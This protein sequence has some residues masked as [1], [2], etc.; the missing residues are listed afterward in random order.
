MRSTALVTILSW[1][2]LVISWEI[3]AGVPRSL[4]EFRAK[5]PYV[6]TRAEG[7]KLVTIR[8]S[9][10]DTDDVSAE[11]LQGLRDANKGGTLNLVKGSTYMIG[12]PLDLT[13]LEDVHVQLDGVIRFTN[14]TSFWQAN[15]FRHPFQN[16][17]MFWKWG[18]KNVVIRGSGVLDGNGQRWWNEFAGGQI[19]D[20]NNTYLRPILFYAQNASG[21]AV[22]GIHLKDSPCWT[23]F[24]VTCKSL[25]RIGRRRHQKQD[26]ELTPYAMAFQPRISH[27]QTWLVQHDQPTR[28]P[29]RPIQI[30]STL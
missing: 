28:L 4:E 29:T 21:L 27:S 5:H 24:I 12:R 7:R 2:V 19:L 18:G 14:D 20:P 23:N 3:P 10:N 17:I 15:A 9:V 22:Q 30:S 26:D 1:V 25:L 11:F 16:S 6:T 13:F 8:A